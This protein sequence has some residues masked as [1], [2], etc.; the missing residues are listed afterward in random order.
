MRRG[1]GRGLLQLYSASVNSPHVIHFLHGVKK[2]PK[3]CH[4]KNPEIPVIQLS[5]P[6]FGWLLMNKP[7]IL[8]SFTVFCYLF[9]G[10]LGGGSLEKQSVEAT[11]KIS[12]KSFLICQKVK[13]IQRVSLASSSLN[14]DSTLTRPWPPHSTVGQTLTFKSLYPIE[15]NWGQLRDFN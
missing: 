5:I 15:S 4:W 3:R 14:P 1:R 6:P 13:K 9:I 2:S 10:L 8:F 12:V 11:W 7:M